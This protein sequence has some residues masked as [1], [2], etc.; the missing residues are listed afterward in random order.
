MKCYHHHPQQLLSSSPIG[1]CNHKQ[2]YLADSIHFSELNFAFGAHRRSWG[3]AP[4]Q[5]AIGHLDPILLGIAKERTK[6]FLSRLSF[7]ELSVAES[8][9]A[10]KILQ[11]KTERSDEFQDLAANVDRNSWLPPLPVPIISNQ[12]TNRPSHG[13]L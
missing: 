7:C 9:D 6:W 3:L 1:V 11:K 12:Q 2:I 13:Y 4:E 10:R 8:C 5:S